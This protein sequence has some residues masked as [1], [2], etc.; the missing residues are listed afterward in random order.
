MLALGQDVGGK[1]W[2]TGEVMTEA[3]RKMCV[4]EKSSPSFRLAV[5][6]S[7]REAEQRKG[8]SRQK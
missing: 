3:C 1:D 4:P 5:L 8:H 2:I 6:Q 7:F